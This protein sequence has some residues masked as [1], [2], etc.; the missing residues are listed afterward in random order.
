[1]A[2]EMA[3]FS[4]YDNQGTSRMVDVSGK[5]VTNR[6][7]RAEGVVRMKS[8]TLDMIEKR[9]LPKG[10]AFEVARVAGILAAK[11]TSGMIPMCHPLALHYVDIDIAV[12]RELQGVK[13]QS[14]IRLDG[15]TGAE[16][17]ALTAVTVAALTIYDM[18]KAVDK[19][20]IIDGITLV[21]KKGGKSDFR[22]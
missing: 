15:K 10:N 5:S 13:I 2:V 12:D 14:E 16:M 17:E 4:H 3:E 8:E 22:K 9:L 11:N 7:A 1:M 18:C 6:S 20:M 21:E 19:E